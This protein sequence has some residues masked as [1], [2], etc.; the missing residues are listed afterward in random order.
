MVHQIRCDR[1]GKETECGEF[2]SE[3]MTSVGF[4]A[5]HS[6]LFGEGNRVEIDL[7]ETC[8]RDTLG[9]WLKVKKPGDMPY[10]KMHPAFKSETG[11]G[12]IPGGG[13]KG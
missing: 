11:G 5:G 13:A 1:C 3:Q 10:A 4:D 2:G 7:C 8:V 9:T 6:S 12:E